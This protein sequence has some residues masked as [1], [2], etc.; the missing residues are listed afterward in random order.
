MHLVNSPPQKILSLMNQ[1]VL[2][3]LRHHRPAALIRQHQR[4]EVAAA[5]Q[6]R[7][8]HDPS[9]NRCM[10]AAFAVSD[11]L[12]VTVM[13]F[14]HLISWLYKPDPVRGQIMTSRLPQK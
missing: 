3:I 5:M 8:T 6:T 4:A 1:A 7:N 13:F 11:L 14:F 12:L 9:F 2:W 10:T